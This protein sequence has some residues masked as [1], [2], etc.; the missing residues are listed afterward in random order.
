MLTINKNPDLPKIKIA[1]DISNGEYGIPKRYW[2][3]DFSYLHLFHEFKNINNVKIYI[4]IS[5]IYGNDDVVNHSFDFNLLDYIQNHGKIST[6]T[7]ELLN[8]KKIRVPLKNKFNY[9]FGS[10][11]L[12]IDLNSDEDNEA[13]EF[14]TYAI[15]YSMWENCWFKSLLRW[16]FKPTSGI[17]REIKINWDT[18]IRKPEV[19]PHHPVKKC[20]CDYYVDE[21]F[22]WEKKNSLK[23]FGVIYDIYYSGWDCYLVSYKLNSNGYNFTMTVLSGR[24]N[25]INETEI[26]ILI[27]L[28]DLLKGIEIKKEKWDVTT[29][30]SYRLSI[31]DSKFNN[32]FG[33]ERTR[34]WGQYKYIE[35]PYFMIV[36]KNKQTSE[37]VTRID[38]DLVNKMIDYF[39]QKNMELQ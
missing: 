8:I 34:W 29:D 15:D 14:N 19:F 21:Y 27:H 12:D 35:Q 2:S 18:L 20:L 22:T 28:C 37:Y 3:N 33:I 24:L 32:N 26:N 36:S 23:Q 31:V 16:L 6:L 25:P 7:G 1:I 39:N 5:F 11:D 30:E 13:N 17:I 10:I 38:F 9:V 4:F